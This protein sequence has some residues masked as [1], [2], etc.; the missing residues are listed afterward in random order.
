MEDGDKPYFGKEDIKGSGSSPDAESP[1][2]DASHKLKDADDAATENTVG[3]NAPNETKAQ[4]KTAEDSSRIS[5]NVKGRRKNGKGEDE[6]GKKKKTGF[7]KYGPIGALVGLVFGGGGMLFG[8]P[9]L[10]PFDMLNQFSN[11]F[12]SLKT[13]KELR[14]NAFIRFQLD[15]D[16][17]KN[18][19]RATVFGTNK[20][21][22]SSKQE[23]K[24]RAQG[25]DVEEMQIGGK[26]TTVMKFNDG[27]GDPKIIVADAKTQSKLEGS[28]A[29]KDAYNDIDN[30][31]NGYIK[32]SRTWRG[33]VGAWFDSIALKFIQSN[34]LTRNRFKA[35]QEKVK[36]EQAGNPNASSNTKE[37]LTDTMK[38]KAQ[39][40]DM[41]AKA[42]NSSGEI[43]ERTDSDGKITKT[44]KATAVEV[45]SEKIPFKMKYS[46]DDMATFKK[47]L[48]DM[49][50]KMG[51]GVAGAVQS[52][53]NITCLIF[54]FIGAVN[55]MLVA[56]ESIQ[57][58][59]LVSSFFEAI[60]K[61]QAG[62]GDDSPINELANGLVT[63]AN[64]T[65]DD[66]N[67]VRENM[68]AMESG[69]MLAIYNNTKADQND[70]SVSSFN[71]GS[72]LDNVFSQLG[73]AAGSFMAC[74]LAKMAAAAADAI[75]TGVEIV[76]CILS[77]GIGCG[78][79]ALQ[80]A[81]TRMAA[82]V[83]KA[84]AISTA[85]T[86][87]TPIA[88]K[89]FAR[90]IIEKLAGEDLGNA[91]VSGANM[92]M[93]DNHKAGG[94]S[95]GTKEKATA[96]YRAQLEVIANEARYQ[97]ETRSPF[98]IT[99]QYTFLGSIVH[100]MIPASV[101]VRSVS[102]AVSTL[103][104]IVSSSVTAMLPTANAVSEAG[105]QY[106]NCPD[107]ESVGAVGDVFCNP[108]II[109]DLATME[110]DPADIVSAIEE[111][112]LT[113]K[114]REEPDGVTVPQIASNSELSKYIL[115]CSERGAPFGVADNN[116]AQKVGSWGYLDT[117]IPTVNTAFN[118]VVSTIPVIG[119]SI[120]VIANSKAAL[121][122]GW[123]TGEACV[124]GNDVG[125]TAP[126]WDTTMNYQRFVED[127]RLLE[128]TGLVEKSA[129][130]AFL[131]D[132]YKE[133]PLDNSYE[134]ILARK[135][136]LTK[137]TVVATLE[138]LDYYRFI[139]SYDPTGMG[140]EYDFREPKT[141]SDLFPSED[142]FD[143]IYTFTA[144]N[145]IV[146]EAPLR[147]RNYII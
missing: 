123:V 56:H 131:D 73:V 55:L 71:I 112:N 26:K 106:G 53:V 75:I 107:L 80:Q 146:I 19:V 51:A 61:V 95:P 20:F 3:N 24:L 38:S 93:G 142:S 59:Q 138:Q 63:P 103:G 15:P 133:N 83:G 43:A 82:A 47:T 65:D 42:K 140:P 85:V 100:R 41:Q 113:K 72:R 70:P 91:L 144:L 126:K 60:Q 2:N 114:E 111:K 40:E 121:D 120:D 49:G 68:T 147:D 77:V 46:A 90:D 86:V 5:S 10:L 4:A 37:V 30:F 13:V 52:T 134:G 87:I 6:G 45:T 29:F 74:A 141:I 76:G 1:V 23:S 84:I 9:A 28:I 35:W 79:A 143:N 66:N 36:A 129:V 118:A 89:I 98:D 102:S 108:Y 101:Q 124:A 99:S 109:S 96:F 57:I 105:R 16:R 44:G 64:T 50:E 34:N 39:S 97:R 139:A 58:M 27:S 7:K 130:S 127:Q 136:G 22:V 92:Y 104:N 81:A 125:G 69:G 25:I 94:G 21:K 128:V 48:N 54:N 67:I 116:I 132:Y 78:V 135:S 18:P 8:I 12:D 110:T 31:R 14:S 32:G 115:F 145:R 88:F 137:E 11:A 33:S 17:I 62:D 119:D 117:D 122:H